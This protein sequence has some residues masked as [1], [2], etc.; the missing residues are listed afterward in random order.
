MYKV[1]KIKSHDWY[2]TVTAT[3]TNDDGEKIERTWE[4]GDGVSVKD[5]V[6]EY[7]EKHGRHASYLADCCEQFVVLSDRTILD[8][9][10]VLHERAQ[11]EAEETADDLDEAY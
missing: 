7:C 5:L 10:E 11:E 2:H 9:L 4:V 3:F 1:E 8:W 6:N